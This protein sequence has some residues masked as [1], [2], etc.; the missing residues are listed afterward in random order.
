MVAGC[1]QASRINGIRSA[2]LSILR[3][4]YCR[5]SS[6]SAPLPKPIIRSLLS[7]ARWTTI[8]KLLRPYRTPPAASFIGATSCRN[9]RGLLPVFWRPGYEVS[10]SGRTESRHMGVCNIHRLEQQE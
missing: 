3:T 7:E 9:T 5:G 2:F 4:T 8:K 10:P 1:Q 6:D